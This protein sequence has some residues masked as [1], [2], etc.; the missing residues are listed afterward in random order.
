[1][2]YHPPLNSHDPQAPYVVADTTKQIDASIVPAAFFNAVQQE[3]LAVIKGAGLTPDD[4]DDYQLAK[5]L[6]VIKGKFYQ[7]LNIDYNRFAS[8]AFIE[9]GN[10][11]SDL[12]FKDT[13][14]ETIFFPQQITPATLREYNHNLYQKGTTELTT[15]NHYT[16]H[17]STPFTNPQYAFF[18]QPVGSD[19]NQTLEVVT[20]AVNSVQFKVE[21]ETPVHI[22]WFAYEIL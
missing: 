4:N 6:N 12:I 13:L 16:L 9:T 15:N 19:L 10:K 21:P 14:V 22:D 7:A 3:I 18:F 8:A 1:M 5:A 20:R 2:I 17:F 11:P